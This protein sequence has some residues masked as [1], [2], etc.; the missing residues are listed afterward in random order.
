MDDTHVTHSAAETEQ[1]GASLARRLRAGDTLLLFGDLGA[2]KTCLVRGLAAG[3]GVEGAVSSP[4]FAIL[5]E[6]PGRAGGPAL[7]HFDCYRL[8]GA[9]A[10]YAEGFDELLGDDNIAVI[11]W[12]E[13]VLDALPQNA[14]EVRLSRVPSHDDDREIRLSGLPDGR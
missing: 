1:W 14:I 5:H 12:P 9:E 8:D 6:H 13:R 11:E 3:L 10:W 7:R 2:G 4:T